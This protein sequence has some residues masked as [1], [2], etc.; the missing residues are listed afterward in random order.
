MYFLKKDANAKNGYRF[1][2]PKKSWFTYSYTDAIATKHV[3][4]EI[5]YPK[6]TK[7]E[8]SKLQKT[9]FYRKKK[10][11]S[12]KISSFTIIESFSRDTVHTTLAIQ[13]LFNSSNQNNMKTLY[14]LF[15][16]II[17]TA[18]FSLT[19]QAQDCYIG[20]ARPG[21][22]PKNAEERA[23]C[24]REILN[25]IVKDSIIIKNFNA[26]DLVI[27][28][29]I[30]NAKYYDSTRQQ[31]Y[32][33]IEPYTIFKGATSKSTLKGVITAPRILGKNTKIINGMTIT[34][35]TEFSNYSGEWSL[36][37]N[38]SGIFFLKK[39]A[40]GIYQF[41]NPKD[42]WVI[43]AYTDGII[44]ENVLKEMLYNKFEKLKDSKY[45]KTTFYHKKKEQTEKNTLK[46]LKSMA[47]I[48]SF[49]RDT[50]PAGVLSGLSKLTI[51]G[52]GF[53]STTQTLFMNNAN[54]TQW[55]GYISL[56][57]RKHITHWTDSTLEVIIPSMGYK[58]IN[59][60]YDDTRKA[61]AG[62]GKIVLYD[63]IYGILD[64][65]AKELV[66]PYAIDNAAENDSIETLYQP[67]ETRL[68]NQNNKG[69]YTFVY[70]TSIY[71]NPLALA[72]FRRAVKTWRCA[73]G[74]DFRERCGEYAFCSNALPDSLVVITFAK[75]SACFYLQQ[76]TLAHTIKNS[77]VLST[78]E[79]VSG[80]NKA[81]YITFQRADKLRY[82][83]NADTT[84]TCPAVWN[85]GPPINNVANQYNFESVAL[86]ELGHALGLKHVMD[87]LLV[88]YYA[89]RA[90][91]DSVVTDKTVPDN[92]T[93]QGLGYIIN[94]DI[95]QGDICTTPNFPALSLLSENTRCNGMIGS[96]KTDQT[97]DDEIQ[98][99]VDLQMRD[100]DWDTG[101]EPNLS[102]G[103]DG[104]GDGWS[105]TSP[106]DWENIW[107]SPD[108][109]NCDTTLNCSLDNWHNPRAIVE[110][111]MGFTVHNAN[112]NL[113][114]DTARLHLHYSLA[115]SG[116]MWP[117]DWVNFWYQP[118]QPWG[119]W[120]YVGEE[121]P[122]SPVNIPPIDPQGSYTNWVNWSPP[123]F[124]NPDSVL[125]YQDPA[126]CTIDPEIDPADGQEK[127]EL[128]LLARIE[129]AQD[130]T[131]N[132]SDTLAIRDYVFNSNNVVTRN[133]FLV[134]PALG[135]G[136]PLPPLVPG[137]PSVMLIA[138]N[139]D[140]IKY[141]NLLFDKFSNGSVAALENMLE[142]SF[143]LS[144]ELWDKWESTGKQGTGIQ[145]I[146][147]R[148]VKITN[149]ETAKLL[150][151]PFDP[152][153]FQ[154]FAIKVTILSNSGKQETLN[155]L[156]NDFSFRITHGSSQPI[157]K[158]SNCFFT[159][160]NLNEQAQ[161]AQTLSNQLICAPNP[162]SNGFNIQFS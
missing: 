87:S 43:Y 47:T 141:L 22:L 37:S 118:D 23:Y 84:L 161:I 121:I 134:D 74:F 48:D 123:N 76:G 126:Y 148:E 73:T 100:N 71:N 82:Y 27:S 42:A 125:S 31:L 160:K 33:E 98:C 38:N 122:N 112:L 147:E 20:T 108:L 65:S 145:I 35:K 40:D 44:H 109:W 6:I 78:P 7:L 39:N 13:K 14:L 116:E 50:V 131:L 60:A 144:P 105:L 130:P 85:F 91:T 77:F 52:S 93:L 124:V 46:G 9:D 149:M 61:C 110:N 150:N 58:P 70:D 90:G 62:T 113:I 106:N 66:V 103:V 80:Y 64:T 19:T 154:P 11:H 96:G 75:D 56:H 142:I 129:S 36:A 15:I 114:S 81:K 92:Y 95:V 155:L 83:C 28:G 69:G 54:H 94:R 132:D 49:S 127:Y 18:L 32:Y 63:A 12:A 29:R 10:E 138:N 3:L 57:P 107:A 34:E 45:Q 140:E 162:F 139:N 21:K 88:M 135:L 120:C 68:Y 101:Q 143:V 1:L 89:D 111:K 24:L 157:N 159:V 156:P 151:I 97:Q 117:T 104:D 5:L 136:H 16:G 119:A 72:A 86:H 115:N 26:A 102:A 51:Y 59:P 53:D 153:E 152:R 67:Y 137:H 2:N 17:A 99:F 8:K 158:P 133:T 146:N 79:C 25:D 55:L 41:V 4:R 128:C 30:A